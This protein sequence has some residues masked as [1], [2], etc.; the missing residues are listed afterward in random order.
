M[1]LGT[2]KDVI[3]TVKDVHNSGLGFNL[4][5]FVAS[6]T[7]Y[8]SVSK[9]LAVKFRELL[10]VMEVHT[11]TLG[12]LSKTQSQHSLKIENHEGRITVLETKPKGE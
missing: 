11:S 6:Y 7:I 5:I 2:T 1:D 3:Q 8:K 4:E 9:K 10:G 12:E